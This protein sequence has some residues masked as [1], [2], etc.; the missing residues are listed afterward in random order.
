[1]Y[2]K[3]DL[4]YYYY[5]YVYSNKNYYL[6]KKKKKKLSGHLG[7]EGFFCDHNDCKIISFVTSLERFISLM[8]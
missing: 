1:M 4:K 5:F 6:L 2:Y 7:A 8:A 3:S